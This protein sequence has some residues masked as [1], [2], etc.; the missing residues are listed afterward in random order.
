MTND[1]MA[2]D[3]MG[4]RRRADAVVAASTA[5]GDIQE[6]RHDA[7]LTRLEEARA[8]TEALR[9]PDRYSADDLA[10]IWSAFNDA[11]RRLVVLRHRRDTVRNE[12]DAL[13]EP[14]FEAMSAEQMLMMLDDGVARSAFEPVVTCNPKVMSGE[15]CFRGTRVPSQTLWDT[16]ADGMSLDHIVHSWPTLDRGD[17]ARALRQAG[18]LMAA[19]ASGRS[20]D[21]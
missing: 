13:E 19:L 15:P 16:L 8:L 20:D 7:A 4:V 18:M 17:C 12:I 1:G 9:E 6:G 5:A 11:R 2:S 21:R 14:A 3:S 10:S